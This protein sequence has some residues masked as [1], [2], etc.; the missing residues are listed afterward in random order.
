MRP[1]SLSVG[2]STATLLEQADRDPRKCS[3]SQTWGIGA[4]ILALYVVKCLGK[5]LLAMRDNFFLSRA[6]P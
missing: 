4:Q 1:L 2:N 5:S 6:N 3:R